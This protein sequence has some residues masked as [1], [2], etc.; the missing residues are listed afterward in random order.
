M[1]SFKVYVDLLG[2]F[3][4]L[5]NVLGAGEYSK[6]QT[7][8]MCVLCGYHSGTEMPIVEE[9]TCSIVPLLLFLAVL[10][11]CRIRTLGQP[12]SHCSLL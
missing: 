4:A 8:D 3:C 10:S 12:Q 6:A 2:I 9:S 11:L 5:S 7:M 1:S